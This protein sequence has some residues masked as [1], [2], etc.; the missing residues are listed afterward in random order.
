M[1]TSPFEPRVD[2]FSGTVV[3]VV[4]AR[5]NRPNLPSENCPFCVGGLEASAPYT[6]K[7]F[8]NRWPAMPDDR[9]E[10]V[11]YSPDHEQ[12]FA[13]L[14]AV[15]V[16]EVLDVWAERS[17]V[18]G[19]RDDVDHVLIFE[20]RGRDVGATIDHPHGQIY[21]FDHVPARTSARITNSWWP[22][23]LPSLLVH[24]HDGW[25]MSVPAASVYP[26]ALEI[27]P[28]T[29]IGLL[30]ELTS[31]QRD[32]CAVML[33]DAL[34]RINTFFG[35]QAPYMLWLNQRPTTSHASHQSAWLNIEIVSPWRATG[36]LRYIA[37]AEVS[38]N[39][40]FNPL[41]PEDL[42]HALRGGLAAQ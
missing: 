37:A 3:H 16:R 10:V 29:R 34:T 5:Q 24:E 32:A 13:G 9:C 23:S 40:Y 27:A 6:V 41:I 36:V 12:T 17:T 7:S 18:L 19:E 42:A 20:N 1:T 21:A 25:T 30:S 38:T 26:V 8:A 15:G 39:E 22:N 2:Q 14:G 31:A 11:L 35:E 4:G 28:L 33:V